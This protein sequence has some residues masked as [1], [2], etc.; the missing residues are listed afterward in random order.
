MADGPGGEGEGQ[1]G[2]G[3]VI[4]S[5]LCKSQ[6]SFSFEMPSALLTPDE[7]FQLSDD[8]ELL[9]RLEES[10]TWER[11]NSATH[12]RSLGEYFSM[13]ANT[14]PHGG[15][16]AVGVNN[17]GT[18]SGCHRLTQQQINSIEKAGYVFCSE[19]R[20]QSRTVKARASDGTMTFIL[21]FR[22]FYRE[23]KV[24]FDSSG[25]AFVRVGDE[26]H[27]LTLDQ[28]RELQIDKG[29]LEF[30]QEPST[31]DYPDDFDISLVRRF[32]D[33]L[34]RIRGIGDGH[35]D[36]ELLEHRHLGK[37]RDGRFVPNNACALLF[38]K[39]PLT[40]FP[41][42]KLLFLRVEGEV[43][44][45][46]DQYNIVKRLPVEGPVPLLIDEAARVIEGQLREFSR[47]GNDGK[48]FSAPEYPKAAWFEA[49]VNACVH[50]SY[51]LRNMNIFVKMF[52]DKLVIESPGGFPPSITP[53]TIYGSHSPRNPH[54]MDAMFYF[55][56]VKEH[57]EGTRRMRDTM[58]GMNLPL[59][60][61]KQTVSGI[62]ASTVRVTL[63]NDVKQRK[64]FVDKDAANIL[65]EAL[66]R[67]LSHEERRV[68]N[69]VVEHHG[70]NVSEC[71]HLIPTLPKWHAAKRFL[72][73]MRAR[74]L[75]V[76]K[77]SDKVLRDSRAYY[78]LPNSDAE[79]SGS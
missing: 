72:E 4:S 38:A 73:S 63:R 68:V 17:D 22:V 20:V 34:R 25:N 10:R 41:G 53:E 61:F 49:L 37:M 26:K 13:W 51:S 65:G 8:S 5:G 15:L 47:L 36:I 23:D 40:T 67:S 78:A 35:T 70:I 55:D 57:G 24:V 6:L 71:L 44:L 14:A 7:L 11:K 48:F 77:H 45:T 39:D 74:G 30:E 58:K 1:G 52:D 54:L 29:Q 43:E 59:P 33:G 2:I 75:L 42:C 69:F 21:L 32:V 62:G 46:G 18:I 76:H 27:Q 50:R 31:L 9:R 19:A 12:S 64:F 66:A 60:E 79:G 28:I 56:F 16:I 3:G